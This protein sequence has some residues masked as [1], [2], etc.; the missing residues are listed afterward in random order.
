MADEAVQVRWADVSPVEMLP[1]LNR[2]T[3]GQTDDMMV[4]EFRVAAGSVVP[5]HSH[6]HQ[7]IGYVISGEVA[8]QFAGKEL[9]CKAG[10][11]CA[12]PGGVEHGAEARAESVLIECF[13][14]PREE[15][16]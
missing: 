11:S 1:G 7:Q 2:R 3:L 16:R 8:Y 6:P 13:S 10:D 12:I 14:P 5:M 9:V 15:Y 4:I